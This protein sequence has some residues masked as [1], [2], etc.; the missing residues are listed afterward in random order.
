MA[1][2]FEY[3]MALPGTYYR[4]KVVELTP[5]GERIERGYH[6]QPFADKVAA[7]HAAFSLESKLVR[8]GKNVVISVVQFHSDVR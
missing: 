8:H 2:R 4:L 7:H 6:N 3:P 1:K 5:W